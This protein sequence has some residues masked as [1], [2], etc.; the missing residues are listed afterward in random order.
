MK[1]ST[2]VNRSLTLGA[3]AMLPV[4]SLAGTGISSAN[5]LGNIARTA[6]TP[7]LASNSTKGVKSPIRAASIFK[8]SPFMASAPINIVP[9]TS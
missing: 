9:G 4:T 2:L 3:L 6:G 8:E 7:I 5:L 1:P